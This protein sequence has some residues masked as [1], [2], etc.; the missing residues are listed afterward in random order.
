MIDITPKNIVI[1]VE[2]YLSNGSKKSA[3]E[4]GD[5]FRDALTEVWNSFYEICTS[6]TNLKIPVLRENFNKAKWEAVA[7][8]LL[9][10]WKQMQS[11]PIKIA[12]AFI[13]K[14]I[15]AQIYTDLTETFLLVISESEKGC[16]QI[17][18]RKILMK[19]ILKSSWVRYV[20]LIAKEFVKLTIFQP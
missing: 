16:N 10:G 3:L 13:E 2:M 7:E 20:I 6:G 12:P 4:A 19:A 18:F 11:F 15:F 9:I 1:N 17:F 8:I 14:C 5:V